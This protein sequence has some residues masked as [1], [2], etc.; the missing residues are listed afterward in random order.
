MTTKKKPNYSAGSLIGNIIIMLCLGVIL[1]GL[2]I[3]A[4][5][6]IMGISAAFFE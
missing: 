5:F 1:F 2:G 6:L 3:M 4:Y